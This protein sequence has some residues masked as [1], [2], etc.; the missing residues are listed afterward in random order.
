MEP[1]KHI[2]SIFGLSKGKTKLSP[3]DLNTQDIVKRP[4]VL[5]AKDLTQSGDKMSDLDLAVTDNNNVI[6]I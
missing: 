3:C 5:K 6:N 2:I 4:Q 1:M